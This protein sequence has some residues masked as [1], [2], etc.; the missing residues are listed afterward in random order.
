[1]IVYNGAS[2][3]YI[4]VN[5]TLCEPLF[6]EFSGDSWIRIFENPKGA[7]EH[8]RDIPAETPSGVRFDDRIF[9]YFQIYPPSDAGP[10]HTRGSTPETSTATGVTF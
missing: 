2:C 3:I 8:Q 7:A 6:V 1:M 4:C 5:G 9:I 10:S